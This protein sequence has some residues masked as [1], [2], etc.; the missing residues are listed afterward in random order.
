MHSDLNACLR[1]V[2]GRNAISI[3]ELQLAEGCSY[4]QALD[5]LRLLRQWG[6]VSKT[7]Q[8]LHSAVNVALRDRRSLTDAQLR[9]VLEALEQEEF[10]L[11]GA[12]CDAQKRGGY[13]PKAEDADGVGRQL[14]KLEKL[15]LIHW[16]D[17]LA[18]SSVDEN[19]WD[20]LRKLDQD[21]LVE[22]IIIILAVPALDWAVARNSEPTEILG[23]AALPQVCKDFI[24]KK[25]DE[26]QSTGKKPDILAVKLGAI[27]EYRQQLAVEM[28]K[29][30][31]FARP[32]LESASSYLRFA[33]MQSI[34]AVTAF[35]RE[36]ISWKTVF[37]S[38]K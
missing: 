10:L 27:G 8:G 31:L 30:V 7:V 5:M 1:H 18:Y 4:A 28:L 38:K 14:E 24:S 13:D 26:F 11:F 19:T 3:P 15:G 22:P 35:F 6:Y 21:K 33:R 36:R 37:R 32:E 9:A 20:R 34:S 12:V 16:F 17:G 2:Q 25:W 29:A 23:I